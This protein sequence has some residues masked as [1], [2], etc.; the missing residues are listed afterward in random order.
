MRATTN[1]GI[2]DF[3]IN[4]NYLYVGYQTEKTNFPAAIVHTV[5]W[6][7]GTNAIFLQKT[8]Q[9]LKEPT[10]GWHNAEWRW[11][12]EASWIEGLK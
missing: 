8:C 4:T 7:I 12:N 1:G 10:N 9:V 2:V 5:T 3:Q 11:F 6:G